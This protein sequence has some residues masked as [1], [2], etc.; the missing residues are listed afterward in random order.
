MASRHC[1]V[2]GPGNLKSSDPVTAVPVAAAGSGEV[3]HDDEVTVV[4]LDEV[5]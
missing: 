1:V 2:V 5:L 4:V 3:R